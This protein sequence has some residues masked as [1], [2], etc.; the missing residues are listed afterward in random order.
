MLNCT[1]P[2]GVPAAGEVDDTVA[3]KVTVWPAT[4]GLTEELSK[5]CVGVVNAFSATASIA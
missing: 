5:V 2:A 1:I 4:D 3:V